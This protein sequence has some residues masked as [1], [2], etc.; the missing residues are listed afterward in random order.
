MVVLPASHPGVDM[1]DMVMLGT[2]LSHGILSCGYLPIR[3][4]FPALCLTVFGPTCEIPGQVVMESFIDYVSYYE[5]L[6][7]N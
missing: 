7:G 2:I 1:Q 6:C 3:L 4:A 5:G